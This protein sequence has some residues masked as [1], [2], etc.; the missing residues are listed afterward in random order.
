MNQDEK[1]TSYW[2]SAGKAIHLGK[3]DHAEPLLYAALDIAEDFHSDDRRL[4]MTL[5]CLAEIL[6]KQR[7]LSQAEGV[8]KRVIAIYEA[9]Y[10]PN[11]PDVGVFT[12]N[13][14]LLYHTQKKHFMAESEYQKALRIQ[15]KA[16]GNSH[17]QTL[18]V[19]ANYARLLKETHREREAQHL[20]ACIEGARTGN[21]R[22]SGVYKAYVAETPAN[23]AVSAVPP[24]A[25]PYATTDISPIDLAPRQ[26]DPAA[27]TDIR[28]IDLAPRAADP[29]ATTDISPVDLASQPASMHLNSAFSQQPAII[30]SDVAARSTR[31]NYRNAREEDITLQDALVVSPPSGR[32]TSAE[33]PAVSVDKQASKSSLMQRLVQQRKSLE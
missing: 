30:S 21:W 13:L 5:E 22:R 19:I 17:P 14:G 1:W 33:N 28:P 3:F 2:E 25:D 12:N 26:A 24:I 15:T 27:T 11:H 8:V 23:Q 20:E 18:N 16:L 10:G 7:Q 32:V 9:R 29:A 6:F 4:A 31:K